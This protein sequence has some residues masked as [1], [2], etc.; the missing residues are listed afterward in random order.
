MRSLPFLLPV[1]LLGCD[2]TVTAHP[3]S[4]P[5]VQ[6]IVAQLS[7][8]DGEVTALQGL[9][10]H[11]Q[12]TIDSQETTIGLLTM[13]LEDAQSAL[14][15]LSGT[16]TE[17]GD[18]LAVLEADLSAVVAGAALQADLDDAIDDFLTMHEK[19]A[20]EISDLQLEADGLDTRLQAL[21][22]VDHA[23]LDRLTRYL[24]VDTASDA[25]VLQGAN[26][27]IQSGSG[28]TDDGGA[29]LGLGNLIVGYD[30]DNGDD[31][32]GSHNLIVGPAHTYRSYGALVAGRDHTASGPLS[33]VLGGEGSTASAT[34][35]VVVGGLD[36]TA[37]GT[38]AVA[39]AGTVNTASGAYTAALGGMEN[40]AEGTRTLIV[41]GQNN[42]ALGTR[43]SG[44]AVFGGAHNSA[45][46][47]NAAVFGGVLNTLS[48]NGHVASLYGGYGV[49]LTP[50]STTFLFTGSLA[51][52]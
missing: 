19:Q 18:R 50:T 8:L 3:I 41:G 33:A 49:S 30:E 12:E 4:A 24:E 20:G 38:Y 29:L 1:F 48:E 17:H 5:E 23:E 6:A 25:V 11:Q 52:E 37:A 21:E 47:H 9:V 43:Y 34:S 42:T 40:L 13:Q 7:T 39:L 45:D 27:Y 2:E 35:A 10:A 22:R 16:G 51:S 46:G 44:A 32:T 28:A 26:V 36:N 31:K 14:A 15:R